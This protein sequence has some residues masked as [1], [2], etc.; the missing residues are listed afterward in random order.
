ML[1]LACIICAS[2]LKFKSIHLPTESGHQQQKGPLPSD[3][4]VPANVVKQI[5][6]VS[7]SQYISGATGQMQIG[8]FICPF[9]YP[10][11]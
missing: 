9:E 1:D 4:V 2:S 8:L 5:E 10:I 6:G 3:P 7:T 11:S